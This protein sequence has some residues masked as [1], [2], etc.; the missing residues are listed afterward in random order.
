VLG[1]ESAAYGLAVARFARTDA[2]AVFLQDGFEF[3]GH[4]LYLKTGELT[5]RDESEVEKVTCLHTATHLL[6]AGLRA[7]LGPE[8]Q[9]DGSDITAER[10][11]FDFRF[12]RKVTR[13]ELKKV[14]AWVDEAIRRD[15][16]VQQEE[17]SYEEA[18]EKGALGFFREKYPPQVKVYSV[19]DPSTGEV[20]SRELC[21]GPHVTHTGEIGRFRILK[22]ESSAAGIRRIRATIDH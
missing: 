3:G 14:E 20:I 9:Q 18:M 16:S 4:G 22:E 12:G 17:M 5:I 15:L 1:V 6:H 13:E 21:G 10:T 11:R 19:G 2:R 7:I 8:V